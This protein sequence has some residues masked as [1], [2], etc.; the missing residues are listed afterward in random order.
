[1][2][3]FKA[4]LRIYYTIRYLTT[5]Q[6]LY[7]IKYRLTPRRRRK[8]SN[9]FSLEKIKI[10]HF[11]SRK[12]TVFSNGDRVSFS[13]LNKSK[14]YSLNNIDWNFKDMGLLW[15][16]N[17]NYFSFLNEQG[18]SDNQ[19]RLLLE[20]FYSYDDNPLLNHSYPI[21]VRVVNVSKYLSRVRVSSSVIVGGL[22]EDLRFLSKNLEFH[23]LGNH[24]LENAFALFIGGMITGIDRFSD[25]GSA[26]LK[27]QLKEQILNDGMHFERSPMYHMIVL[28]RLLDTINFSRAAKNEIEPYLK[29]YALRMLGLAMNWQSLTRI[30]MMQDST[31]GVALELSHLFDYAGILLGKEVPQLPNEFSDSGYRMLIDG[32]FGLFINV[33]A[34]APSYQPG[35]SHADELNFE[36]FYQGCPVIVDTGIS[37]Y[38]INERRS[39]E[40]S[41]RSHNCVTIDDK[42]SSD[43]WSSFRVGKRAKVEL[44]NDGE[45]VTARHFGYS[46]VVVKRSWTAVGGKVV[47]EDELSKELNGLTAV[48]RL[49]FHP[50][51]SIK[52][53]DISQYKLSNGL[54]L[55]FEIA[56]GLPD[57]LISEYEYSLG[58]NNTCKAIKLAYQCPKKMKII[59]SEE[60]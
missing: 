23:L 54:I 7:Q 53:I 38:D 21:S 10:D 30:P 29:K 27:V 8:R 43:V 42:N 18:L 9:N 31:Y 1:M 20:N 51:I 34:I 22:E 25:L 44:I 12:E 11:S 41:T 19:K 58:F 2:F 4:M 60:N 48:G 15:G 33:G 47:I 55:R 35:H 50:D 13:Y 5:V 37:T 16:Y 3:N 57:I 46:P 32:F 52:Q 59:I 36:L 6:I 45:R 26:I 56:C 28:E 49:H 24:L 39:L 17:L 14:S 40:R